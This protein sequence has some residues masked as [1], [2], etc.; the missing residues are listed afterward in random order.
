[1]SSSSSSTAAPTCATAEPAYKFFLIVFC[2]CFGKSLVT[3]ILF[4]E[5]L[6]LT[7]RASI[8]LTKTTE[9]RPLLFL[10]VRSDTCSTTGGVLTEKKQ[11]NRFDFFI[12][13]W[14]KYVP[15]RCVQKHHVLPQHDLAVVGTPVVS[16]VSPSPK[17]CFKKCFNYKL[18]KTFASF[19]RLT[20]PGCPGGPGGP[21][22]PRGPL[23]M[24]R[25]MFSSSLSTIKLN[26]IKLRHFSPH[27]NSPH[28][29]PAVF[30]SPSSSANRGQPGPPR[31]APLPLGPGPTRRP[32]V[33][34]RPGRTRTALVPARPRGTLPTLRKR[35]GDWK[36]A[37]SFPPS[38][39]KFFLPSPPWSP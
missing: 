33:P 19:L 31:L 26:K 39:P 38:Q 1:M 11:W 3:S 34:P 21:G 10:E 20:P 27:I 37:F 2:Q 15:G 6:C 7:T 17:L 8:A 13:V 12:F 9:P 30:P 24:E 22:G 35:N 36:C 5:S 29:L 23:D 4:Q 28:G 16:V 18:E 32:G 25:I 14:E